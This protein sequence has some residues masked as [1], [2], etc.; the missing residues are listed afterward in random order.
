MLGFFLEIDKPNLFLIQAQ[1]CELKPSDFLPANIM[2]K[3]YIFVYLA[4][5]KAFA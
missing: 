1:W 5:K 4:N 3:G 2:R